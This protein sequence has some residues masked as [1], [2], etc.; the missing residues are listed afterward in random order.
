MVHPQV[1]CSGYRLDIGVV[2]PRAPGRY[3]LGVECDGATYHSAATA[4]D[5]DRLR[6]HVLESLGWRIHRIW[7]TDWWL[8]PKRELEKLQARLEELVRQNPGEVVD[9]P[10]VAEQATTSELVEEL[11]SIDQPPQL[12]PT[13]NLLKY[14]SMAA[15]PLGAPDA[16]YEPQSTSAL[17]DNMTHVLNLEGPILEIV[18]YKRVAR[19]WGLERTGSRIVNRLKGLAHLRFVKTVDGDKT[20][21]WPADVSPAD[22]VDFRVSSGDESSR[23]HIDE[24]ALEEVGA[25]M[26][27]ILDQAGGTSRQEL[28][29][30]TCRM[31][32]M[33]R[34][35]AD[36]EARA[37]QAIAHLAARGRV[38]VDGDHVRSR[39]F[40]ES[41]PAADGRG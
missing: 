10:T 23:R 38:V 21:F 3:L 26:R 15:L 9:E 40:A 31:L 25:V 5:R 27:H 8:D 35:A 6:Q 29:R 13:E 22:W 24:V 19:A 39:Q 33:N 30:T 4:R 7:S 28:A 37:M 16:F 18:L 11:P 20:F 2:D 12:V 36:A 14:Y 17:H 34:V 1:G 32:G 41:R